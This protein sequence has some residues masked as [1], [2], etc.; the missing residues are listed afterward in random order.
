VTCPSGDRA[1]ARRAVAGSRPRRFSRRRENRNEIETV[2]AT[3]SGEIIFYRALA[4]AQT[5][6]LKIRIDVTARGD[7]TALLRVIR[8]LR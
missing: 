8:H 2:V 7:A 4:R 6:W 5:A 3:G 1:D